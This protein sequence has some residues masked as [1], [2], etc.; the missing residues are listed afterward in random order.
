MVHHKNLIKLA[1]VA[2]IFIF[3]LTAVQAGPPLKEGNPGVPGLLA[4]IAQLEQQVNELQGLLDI[5]QNY[6]RLA[7]TGQ[8]ISCSPGDDGSL[9]KGIPWPDPRFTDNGDGT[10]N[11]NL[12][13]LIWLQDTNC[14][15]KQSWETALDLCNNLQQGN[16][17]LTDS[18]VIG[19]WRPPNRLEME[20]LLDFGRIGPA[21]PLESPFVHYGSTYW[22][23]T[24]LNPNVA[25]FMNAS[26]VMDATPTSVIWQVW[27][28]RDPK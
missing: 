5:I 7:Q 15:G 27:P 25:W 13:R 22:T 3:S 12:T 6:A 18:S 4:K 26:G 10:V 19:D 14:F 21:L 23:S 9:R 28:V 20:S 11:D 16:C 2:F 17:N 8:K 24:T 1:I